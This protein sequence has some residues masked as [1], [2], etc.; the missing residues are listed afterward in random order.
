MTRRCAWLRQPEQ[1]QEAVREE[2]ARRPEIEMRTGGL[3]IHWGSGGS[4]QVSL[5]SGDPRAIRAR[6][7]RRGKRRFVTRLD[8]PADLCVA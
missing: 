8:L 1:A 6:G 2:E 7:R 4:V 3:G 5:L